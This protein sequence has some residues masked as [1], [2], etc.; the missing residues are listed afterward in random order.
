MDLLSVIR[1][2]TTNELGSIPFGHGMRSY[3]NLETR[4]GIYEEEKKFPRAYLYPVEVQDEIRRYQ[5]LSHKYI[6]IMDFLTLCK[7]SD[8]QDVLE[9]KL[10]EMFNLSSKFLYRLS[11]H[12]KVK[13][14][15]DMSREPNYHVFDINLCGWSVSFTIELHDYYCE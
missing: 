3:M 15:T 9:A 13:E 6:C 14:M 12:P 2:I 1:D 10:N 11:L 4:R 8:P 7:I 5:G